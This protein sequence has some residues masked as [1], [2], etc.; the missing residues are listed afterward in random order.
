VEEYLR[1]R[2]HKLAKIGLA[3]IH[4][5]LWGQCVLYEKGNIVKVL[6]LP[7]LYG[8]VPGHGPLIFSHYLL[9][10]FLVILSNLRLRTRFH[11]VIGISSFNAFLSILL[12]RLGFVDYVIY[13]GIDYPFQRCMTSVLFRWLDEFSAKNSD[14][15]WDLSPTISRAR[16]VNMKSDQKA[17]TKMIVPLTYASRILTLLSLNEIER[18]T[19]AFIGT[20]NELQGLQLLIEAMPE[21]VRHMPNVLVRVIGDGP[22]A[23]KLK[24]MVNKLG[25]N[26]HFVFYGFIE[27]DC[28]V[29]NIISRCAIGVALYVPTPE[30]NALAADPGKIKFYT[31]LGLPVIATKTPSGLLIARSG[32]GITI[33]YDSNELASAVVKLLSDTQLLT[34]YRQNANSFAQSYTSER[35]FPEIFNTTLQSLDRKYARKYAQK[36]CQ[37]TSQVCRHKLHLLALQEIFGKY[38]SA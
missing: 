15:I 18:W 7:S 9:Q 28:D 33:E 30:N 32:A 10:T 35:V 22:Y 37:I 17:L 38:I 8:K 12:R 25:L 1:N 20:L 24:K 19:M 23:D 21:I 2:C 5:R 27:K 13:Y 14:V 31:F 29:I 4:H 36:E 34:T 6:S 16:D 3:G 26:K 11:F